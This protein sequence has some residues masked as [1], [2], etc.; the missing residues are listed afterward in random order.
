MSERFK[1]NKCFLCEISDSILK[2]YKD[3]I[4]ANKMGLV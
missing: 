1:I 2:E 3:I 4:E